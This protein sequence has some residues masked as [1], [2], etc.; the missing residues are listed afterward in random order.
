MTPEARLRREDVALAL[1]VFVAFAPTLV[2]GFLWDDNL[3]LADSAL[4]QAADG[5]Q[6]AWTRGAHFDYYPITSTAFWI[7]WRI[8]GNAAFGYH[9]LN[10]VLH[11][12]GAIVL[13]RVLRRVGLPGAWFAAAVWAVHPVNVA[14]V[15]WISELKSTLSFPLHALAALAWLTPPGAPALRLRLVAT[16]FH[17]ASLLA[18][19]SGVMLPVGLLLLAL[20]RGRSLRKETIALAPMFLISLAAGLVTM[21]FQSEGAIGRDAALAE[22]LPL[23]VAAAGRAVWFYL[24]KALFP[25]DLAS[26]YARDEIAGG[27][28]L[29]P[30]A[31]LGLSLG[32]LFVARR[33]I[34]LVPFVAL[35]GY[36]VTLLPILGFVDVYYSR[37]SRVADHWQYAALPWVV[38][39]VVA[40][41]A[42]LL[43]R[44]PAWAPAAAG[45]ACVGV[46]AV[47][48]FE[49][50]KLYRDAGTFWEHVLSR[51]ATSVLAHQE[52]G[53]HLARSGDAEGARTH[54][55]EAIR[56]DPGAVFAHA[57]L[58]RIQERAGDYDAAARSYRTA[59]DLEPKL[60]DARANLGRALALRGDL[61]GA[62]VELRR[63]SEVDPRYFEP[64]MN[65]ALIYRQRGEAD[66]AETCFE[67]VVELV[68]NHVGAHLELA[69]LRVAKGD[70]AG[71]EAR[72]RELL[73][74][75]P[76]HEEAKA[77][78][79]AIE[80]ELARR[81]TP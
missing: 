51:D 62:I 38:C 73:R 39:A 59:A 27:G 5:W 70:L 36:V 61:E 76:E 35:A 60:A 81:K 58:G 1:A 69:R 20:A 9:L 30:I 42:R 29:L 31:A 18:K 50:S 21:R 65:L 4:T 78:L 75:A 32:A 80:K 26:V 56:I 25:T 11:A 67:R 6:G 53:V 46:L 72:L 66:S 64:Q 17:A 12:A 44:A 40:G 54:L 41:C 13:L 49:R 37:W 57:N 45:L 79:A 22:P 2:A 16:V 33:R 3:W 68:P 48:S 34:G 71:A 15:G 10:L 47:L 52:L 19:A 63:A 24:E 7:A 55:E 74:I 23:R 28:S 77:V 8:F 43:A 14:T